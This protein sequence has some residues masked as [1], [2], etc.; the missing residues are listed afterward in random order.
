MLNIE[1]AI[2]DD[3]VGVAFRRLDDF[4]EL[5]VV[6]AYMT[7]LKAS[8]QSAWGPYMHALPSSVSST[9]AFT[10][11]E[12]EQLQASHVCHDDL[13]WRFMMI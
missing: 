9:L 6:A 13:F 11:S 7:F 5:D 10:P 4:P 2:S 8:N 12:L 1:H 3:D